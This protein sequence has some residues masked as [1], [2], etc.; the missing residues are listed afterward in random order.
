M[1]NCVKAAATINWKMMAL[2]YAKVSGNAQI[3][4]GVAIRLGCNFG[5]YITTLQILHLVISSA[6]VD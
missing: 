2:M 5:A 3:G 1:K 6:T 4:Y